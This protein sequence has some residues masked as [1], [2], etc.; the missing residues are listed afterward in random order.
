MTRRVSP[1]FVG[2]RSC[3]Q[4]AVHHVSLHEPGLSSG[5]KAPQACGALLGWESAFLDRI[6]KPDTDVPRV[7]LSF[8]FSPHILASLPHPS[9]CVG[10]AAQRPVW[11]PSAQDGDSPLL[12]HQAPVWGQNNISS[13]P[14]VP[15]S[16]AGLSCGLKPV[17]VWLRTGLD[18]ENTCQAPREDG[19]PQRKMVGTILQPEGGSHGLPSFSS[20]P[21]TSTMT[22]HF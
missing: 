16:A 17:R 18:K 21:L 11:C 13:H 4:S 2:R 8:F 7:S 5:P 10:T 3:Q 12:P 15:L 1:P 19:G 14:G 20:L 22:G 6:S 9:C